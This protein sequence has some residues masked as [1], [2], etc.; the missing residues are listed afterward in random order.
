MLKENIYIMK[1]QNKLRE[2]RNKYVD[3]EANSKD[4]C[5]VIQQIDVL[6]FFVSQHPTNACQQYSNI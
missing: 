5:F 3:L 4:R 2:K 6:I 1:E